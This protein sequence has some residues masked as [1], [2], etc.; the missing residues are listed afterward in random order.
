MNMC[1]WF[2]IPV[3]DIGRAMMFYEQAFN[4]KLK[5]ME[6]EGMKMASFPWQDKD[7]GATGA[8]VE[9]HGYTP[10]HQGSRIYLSVTNIDDT[11]KKIE[12]KGGK[13]LTPRRSIGE[14][15][16]IAFFEDTEGNK[17]ALHSMK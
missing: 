5:T 16:F 15:G 14:Y 13:T 3:K 11:L 7:T 10:S 2:E 9:G 17:V 1:G 6:A 12:T 4:V 8:L